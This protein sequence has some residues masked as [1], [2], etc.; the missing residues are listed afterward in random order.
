MEYG[1]RCAD[2]KDAGDEHLAVWERNLPISAPGRSRFQWLYRDN[3]G[4][5][6]RLAMLETVSTGAK[7]AIV[8]AAGSG[9]R[10]FQ[11][12]AEL[13]SRRARAA[14][15]A[16]VAVDR[17]HRAEMPEAL[18]GRELRRDLL[19]RHDLVY[20]FPGRDSL[21][22]LLHLGYR[23]L[24][25]T[26][27]FVLVLRHAAFLWDKLGPEVAAFGGPALNLARA[28]LLGA[29]VALL[30]SQYRFE[31]VTEG[32]VDERFD[33]LWEQARGDYPLIGVRDASF[34]RWRFLG[35]PD[36]RLELGALVNKSTNAVEGYAAI[37]RQGETA[38]VHD[39]FAGRAAL[40]PL[41]RMLATALIR[42]RAESISLRLCGAPALVTALSLCGFRE[43][44]DRRTVVVDV[45]PSLA[46]VRG[47]V[48]DVENW[49]LTEADRHA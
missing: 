35:R 49:Y 24:G 1:I 29:R 38:Y 10:L 8:G 32:Q 20:G 41:L 2:P 18:L 40:V 6:G 16:D 7:P 34:V 26:R 4:G 44:E 25:E 13:G 47:G 14:L 43:R 30:G 37:G 9:T 46:D 45:G 22:R 48:L 3:P 11:L 17:A 39:L 31:W 21:A 28:A 27:R 36:G 5:P 19:E 23:K 42:Q 12:G 15:L 33:Q